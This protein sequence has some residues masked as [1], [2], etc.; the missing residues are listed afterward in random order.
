MISYV[1]FYYCNKKQNKTDPAS[2]YFLYFNQEGRGNFSVCRD[3]GDKIGC[4][5]GAWNAVGS[6]VTT[7]DGDAIMTRV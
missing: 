1:L 2:L 3:M 7:S 4:S 5:A 6:L